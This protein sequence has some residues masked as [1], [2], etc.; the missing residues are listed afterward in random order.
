MVKV[1]IILL[2]LLTA[3]VHLSFFIPDP[4]GGLIYGL[5]ALGYVT[6]LALLYLPIPLLANYQRTVRWLL[7]GFT[8]LT[9]V[10]YLIFGVVNHEWT[11]PLG[12]LDKLGEVILIGLLWRE[13]QQSHV[14]ARA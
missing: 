9:I 8:A 6:L 11:T 2:T 4:S 7:I 14:A 5:N 1:I 3:A 10:A 12:P 13:G